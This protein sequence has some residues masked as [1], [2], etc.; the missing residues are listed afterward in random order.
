M[1]ILSCNN[2][3]KSFGINTILDN[4][5]FDLQHDD[6]VSLVGINGAGKSTIFKIIC[7]E[8]SKD[9]GD[10]YFNNNASLGYLSQSMSLESNNTIIEEM[11]TVYQNIIDMENRLRELELLISKKEIIADEVYHN[12]LMLEYSKLLETFNENNGYSY[13]SFVKGVLIGLGFNESDFGKKINILSGGQKTRVSLGKL[14]LMNPNILLLDEPTNHLDIDAVEWLEDYLKSYK[15]CV[16]IISH[17][18]FFLDTVTNKTL[19]LNNT[20]IEQYNG[21]YSYYIKE[22]QIRQEN[23]IKQYELQQ[24]SIKKQEEIIDRF[25]SFNREKSIK[26]AE[27]RQKALD[28]IEIIDKPSTDTKAAK[29]KFETRVKSGNNV[30]DII[31]LCKS[32]NDKILF[33]DINFNIKK[34]ERIALIGPNGTGKT[35][36]FKIIMNGIKQNNGEIIWGHNVITGY[37]D[38]EISNLDE[39]K[40]II[41]EIWDVYSELTQTKI[42]T[43]LGSFLFSDD[44]VFKKINLL[45]GGEKSRVALLKLMLSQAN[46][47]LLDEPTNHL[48]IISKE[49]LEAALLNYDGT[50]LMISHDRYFINKIA[51]KILYMDK[52]N[53]I[54]EYLGNYSYYI[55]KKGRPTRFVEDEPQKSEITKTALKEEKRR[56]KE[57]QLKEKEKK[58]YVKQLEDNIS[59]IENK[60]IELQ[61]TLCLKDIYSNPEKSQEIHND[62]KAYE[63][64]LNLLYEEWEKYI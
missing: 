50:L 44:D 27:S 43:L 2:I 28:R 42:R 37:Y 22:K 46:F 14:L 34:G 15:G 51:T 8:L 45:S 60:I 55:E 36:L 5:S 6:R 9:S 20:K 59:L 58:L 31:N 1:I 10:I 38:Q 19:E 48:D 23:A 64:K 12:K 63:E 49:A 30:V 61:E 13:K 52:E 21:N 29:I 40:A 39:S 32:F 7:N 57:K 33:K 47:L 41:D 11:L 25:K 26:Q 17:D 16:F 24:K 35:T 4:V 3:C 56:E 54:T 18:R 53:G 62:L